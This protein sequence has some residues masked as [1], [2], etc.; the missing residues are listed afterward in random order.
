M[1]GNI[2]TP[3]GVLGA[4]FVEELE[5]RREVGKWPHC[6]RKFKEYVAC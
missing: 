2:R 3:T 6:G 4:S 5:K 1:K